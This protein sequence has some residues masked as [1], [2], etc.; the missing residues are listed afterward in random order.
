MTFYDLQITSLY[1]GYYENK[2]IAIT[3]ARFF[4]LGRNGERIGAR[5][6]PINVTEKLTIFRGW[7]P[8]EKYFLYFPVFSL[9]QL[10]EE[11]G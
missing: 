11:I 6:E 9:T 7:A 5:L 2:R 4:L 10:L 1:H 8:Y 3:V